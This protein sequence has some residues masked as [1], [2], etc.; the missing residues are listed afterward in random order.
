MYSIY[1]LQVF[2]ILFQWIN[3][4]S[5]KADRTQYR[6]LILTLTYLA[7]NT[8]WISL[9]AMLSFTTWKE[10]PAIGYLGILMTG[11]TCFYIIKEIELK[12]PKRRAI[13]L[14]LFLSSVYLVQQIS[15][16]YLPAYVFNY[17]IITIVLFLQVL[18][19]IYATRLIRPI[20]KTRMAGGSLSPI[21]LAT[22]IIACIYC[23][24]PVVFALV[25]ESYIEF[26]LINAPFVIIGFAYVSHHVRRSKSE[27]H[28][29]TSQTSSGTLNGRF[30]ATKNRINKSSTECCDLNLN[31]RN[32]RIAELLA[33]HRLTDRE[34]EIAIMI[35]NGTPSKL[36]AEELNL[37]YN[38]IRWHN[39]QLSEKVG[40]SGIREFREKYQKYYHSIKSV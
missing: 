36:I 7:F 6:F 11:Y 33:E 12:K 3:M 10:I 37:S 39:K 30:I 29:L 16:S 4:I 18:T 27:S 17:V 38:T 19:L 32:E 40:V 20:I 2:F 35:L 1:T 22:M 28:M 15:K 14:V 31:G 25:N 5:R 21:N 9:Q 23:F 13:E 8:A 24:S 34:L 26:I